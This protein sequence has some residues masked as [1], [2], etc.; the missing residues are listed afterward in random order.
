MWYLTYR[1]SEKILDKS[2]KFKNL[3]EVYRY[4]TEKRNISE[5]NLTIETWD[6]YKQESIVLILRH[7][8]DRERVIYIINKVRREG[9]FQRH[10]IEVL[11]YLVT[12]EKYKMVEAIEIVKQEDFLYLQA[13]SYIK[14]DKYE[15]LAKAFIRKMYGDI[16]VLDLD[17]IERYFDYKK[18]GK[19]LSLDY[20]ETEEGN[21]IAV[22]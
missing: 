22:F 1:T 5:D 10:E 16:K 8:E 11:K 12:K 6:L 14:D 18:L 15:A 20:S 9:E 2:V 4:L 3:E 19:E 13:L 17:T 21:F 7:K